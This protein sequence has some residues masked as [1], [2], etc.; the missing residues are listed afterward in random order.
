MTEDVK[1]C[2]MA[3]EN[4]FSQYYTVPESVQ[5]EVDAFLRELHAL[6]EASA[7]ATEFE[8]AF[9][10]GGL[11]QTFNALL[12]K[13]TPKPVTMTEEQKAYSKEVSKEIYQDSGRNLGKEIADDVTDSLSVEVEEELIAQGRK[14]MIEAGTFD[15][16]TRVSNV[17]EDGK[18]LFGFVKGLFGKKK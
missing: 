6:G 2:V 16:F 8:S 11:S 4:F 18:N 1:S 3:R 13:C 15:E 9:A 5:P 17:V 12:P 14:T 7:N 10:S